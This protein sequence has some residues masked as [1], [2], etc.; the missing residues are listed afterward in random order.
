MQCAEAREHIP[1]YLAGALASSVELKLSEHLVECDACRIESEDLMRMWTDL[2]AIPAFKPRYQEMRAKFDAAVKDGIHVPQR[3]PMSW[4]SKPFLVTVAALAIAIATAFLL[5]R[6]SEAPQLPALSGVPLDGKLEGANVQGLETAAVTLVEYGDYE[7]PPCA[8][9]HPIVN[10]LMQRYPEKLKVEFRHFPLSGIHANAVAAAKAAEAAG[11]QGR[12]WE[13]HDLLLSSQKDWTGKSNIEAEF[14]AMASR[15][16]LDRDRFIQSLR[17]PS[18]EAR[19]LND[20]AAGKA[21][22]VDSTPTFFLNGRKLENAPAS[23]EQFTVLIESE[24]RCLKAR[25][26]GEHCADDGITP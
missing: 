4:N 3:R 23:V 18:T 10:E 5:S 7:C 13:M 1:E 20:L 19:V 11:E 26:A 2:E 24:L 14:I 25:Q 17:S 9:Y 21:A 6:Q 15:L 22:G 8:H 12:Y 16:N